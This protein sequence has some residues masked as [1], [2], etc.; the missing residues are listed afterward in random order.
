MNS[1]QNPR[2]SSALGHARCSFP[3]WPRPKIGIG[4]FVGLRRIVEP[5]S[6]LL[7]NRSLTWLVVAFSAMTLAEWGYVT[8]LAVD[9]FRMHG[10][11]AVG[12]VGFRLFVASVAS[13][14]NF[15]Y[16]ERHPNGGVLTGIAG[17]RAVIVGTSAGLAAAGA[18]LAPLLVLV[19]MDALVSAP[20]RPA[21]SA[22]LPVL[23]RTPERTC[24]CRSRHQHGEDAQPGAWCDRRRLPA[25][26]HASGRGLRRSCRLDG[27][28]RGSTQ[29]FARPPIRISENASSGG[30]R[31]W[32]ATP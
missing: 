24:R 27:V 1:V 20:Y 17:T 30:M 29:Q 8:A 22:M 31:G 14:F 2:P 23:A 15:P 26:R 25:G 3:K 4:Q 12:L 5:L 18:P 9:A 19:A 7:D 13:F 16:L 6:I 10:S 21:Q 11:V 32:C 28:G